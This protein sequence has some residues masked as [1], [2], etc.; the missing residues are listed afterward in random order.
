MKRTALAAVLCLVI[1]RAA[2]ADPIQGVSW[3]GHPPGT[4]A[5]ITSINDFDFG[6]EAFAAGEWTITW[7]GGITAWRDRTTIGLIT[8]IGAEGVLFQPGKIASGTSY[9]F[10]VSD[11]WML[12]AATPSLS[13]ATSAGGQWVFASLGGGLWLWGLEDILLGQCDCDWQDAYGT[14]RFHPADEPA[15]VPEPATLGLVSMGLL[16]AARRLRRR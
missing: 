16:W 6:R 13:K 8:A 4:L 7:S 1:A 15:P 11:S 14:L 12:W 3:D 5:D 9:T 10:D 2:A